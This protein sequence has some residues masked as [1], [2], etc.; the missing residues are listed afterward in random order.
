MTDENVE[1]TTTLGSIDETTLGSCNDTIL[2]SNNDE[3]VNHC[4]G[5]LLAGVDHN[6][7]SKPRN[8]KIFDMRECSVDDIIEDL[9][10]LD[11]V[12]DYDIQLIIDKSYDDL[13]CYRLRKTLL[14]IADK[15]RLDNEKFSIGFHFPL[16]HAYNFHDY[17]DKA[18]D[19]IKCKSLDDVKS[20]EYEKIY[21]FDN[22]KTMMIGL[23]Y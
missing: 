4:D 22:Y 3:G 15:K 23:Y 13:E 8:I 12:R 19:I 14:Y 20:L 6:S 17:I 9:T 11:N 18:I 16:N 10:H 5:C 2:C 1:I 21:L 7:K